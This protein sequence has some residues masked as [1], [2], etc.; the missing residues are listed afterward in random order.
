VEIEKIKSRA[1]IG[2]SDLRSS[3]IAR[4]MRQSLIF[5]SF[6]YL[7]VLGRLRKEAQ[8]VLDGKID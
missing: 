5:R 7:S 3:P 6:R 4:R 1:S 2:F 8:L